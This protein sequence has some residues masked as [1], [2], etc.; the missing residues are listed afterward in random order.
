MLSISNFKSKLRT[1]G[2][3]VPVNRYI[4]NITF[5]SGVINSGDRISERLQYMCQ[6]CELPGRTVNMADTSTR[7]YGPPRKIPYNTSFVD[8]TMQFMVSQDSMREKRAFDDWVN[9]IQDIDT[10]DMSYYDN[11]VGE[12]NIKVLNER[13]SVIYECILFE[14]F[15]QNV[16]V[17]TLSMDGSTDFMKF[18]VTMAYRKWK[19][20]DIDSRDTLNTFNFMDD[21]ESVMAVEE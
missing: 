5:P 9:L 11:L 18:T 12:V 7:I 6:S 14:A 19:K 15:P 16:S 1:F 8:T 4:P 21:F 13:N 20:V 10:F 3:P 2:G 17:V